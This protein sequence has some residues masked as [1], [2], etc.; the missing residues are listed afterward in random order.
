MWK[1]KTAQT[2]AWTQLSHELERI[3]TSL[4][5]ASNS[6][7]YMPHPHWHAQVE[8]NHIYSGA[9][10]YR[11]ANHTVDLEAGD[12]CIFWGGQPHQAVEVAPDTELVAI[13]L[14]LVHFFRLRLSGE[15]M[16][17]LTRGATVV[18]RHEGQADGETFRRLTQYMN[19]DD[20]VRREHAIDELL[21]RLNRIN[22]EPY[23]L[24]DGEEM[25]R[26][27]GEPLDAQGFRNVIEICA[28]ITENFRHDIGSADVA[29]HVEIHPKY[30]MS[31]FK[32]STGMTL[33]EYITLLRLSYAQSLL[34]ADD[35]TVLDVAMESGFGSLSA[36]NQSFRKVTGQSPSD[37]RRQRSSSLIDA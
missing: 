12:V 35:V 19:S 11:M 6:G 3:P 26:L 36:F 27:E 10:T 29:S 17:R 9:M 32:K 18:T 2:K 4:V 30:A 24:V 13:H 15:L 34:L 22:F 1:G 37:F 28:Y 14:P 31:V 8:V 23:R 33:N 20:P 16:Q 5:A 25:G 7:C 21:L